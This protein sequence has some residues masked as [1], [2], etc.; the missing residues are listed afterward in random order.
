MIPARG[1]NDCAAEGRTLNGNR[2]YF[3]HLGTIDQMI[4]QL[5]GISPK[6]HLRIRPVRWY[7]G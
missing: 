1:T 4:L 6:V 5:G 2:V 3:L 7:D